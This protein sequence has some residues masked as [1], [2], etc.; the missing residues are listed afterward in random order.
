MIIKTDS[1]D[2]LA[3]LED[4]SNLKGFA[5][6]LY[7]PEN[8]L[9]ICEI[10]RDCNMRRKPLTCSGART[11][12]TGGCVPLR[13]GILSLEKLNKVI[14]IEVVDKIA[15][16]EAG[17]PLS[18][19]EEKLNK[20][21]LTFSPQPTESLALIGSAVSTGASGVRGFKYGSIRSY[22]RA[23]EIVL[24]DGT[25]MLLKRGKVKAKGRNFFFTYGKKDFKFSLP[26]YILPS[27]KTQAGYFVCENMDL[28]DLFIGSEGTLGVIVAVEIAVQNKSEAIFDGVVFFDTEKGGFNFVE[29]VIQRKKKR[30]FSPTSIEFFDG[31]SLEFLSDEYSHIPKKGCAIYFEQEASKDSYENLMNMW[32][33][34]FKE[35]GVDLECVWI[36]DNPRE[37]LRIYEFRHRLPEKINEF[38]RKHHQKK[39]STDI[40][41]PDKNFYKMYDFYKKEAKKLKISYVNFG[42]IGERHLHFNFLPRNEEEY[43]LGQET[44]KR[45]IHYSVSLKGT[46]SAE[47]GIGKIKKEY[48]K[49]MFGIDHIKEMAQLKA[50]FDP[51][52]ILGENNIFDKDIL[53]KD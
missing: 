41:V 50:Y 9:E 30:M 18:V 45:F 12:T 51:Y 24:S 8:K 21:G 31:N 52:F 11:G 40:A 26:T 34:L 37:R 46:V 1:S 47:H 48:L 7:I 25:L 17:V 33:N 43:L 13:G 42:H 5:D 44:I 38:L 4:T 20:F 2:F 6:T 14:D 27:V 29:K 22:I 3:Y 15:K 32:I 10:L 39:L 35:S 36:G 19:L 53:R 49:V 23:I 16:V 28:I